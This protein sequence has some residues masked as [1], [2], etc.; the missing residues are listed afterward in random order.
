VHVAFALPPLRPG[1]LGGSE[2]NARG[3]LG[4]FARGNGPDEVTVLASKHVHEAFSE[5]ARGPVHLH[6]VASYPSGPSMATRAFGM[7]S[8][9]V[10]PGLVARHVPPGIEVLHHPVTVP[11]PR[12]RVPTVITLLDL[13]H[14]GLPAHLSS[15]ERAYRRVAYERAARRADV[16]ITISEHSRSS[17]IERA[18]LS[19][20]RV[21]VVPPGIDRERFTPTQGEADLRLRER[22]ALPGR[23]LVYPANLWPHKNHRRLLEALAECG[24]D[25]L[26]LVLSGRKHGRLEAL[27]AEARSMGLGDRVRHTGVLAPDELPVLLRGAV[28]MVFPSFYED[29]GAPLLEAMA[30]GCPVACSDRGSLRETAGEAALSF[31]PEYVLSIAEAL[32]RIASDEVL[33]RRLRAAGL[34]RAERFTWEAA[35]ASH[36][37]IYARAAELR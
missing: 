27:L 11:V 15:A 36:R 17:L 34:A 30:C 2:T 33:R 8:A 3:L 7:L 23:Y 6:R 5:Y 19:P 31:N 4:Q 32:D 16:V 13:Q 18:G 24:D 37:A 28:A 35:A 20:E 25:E 22:L 1:H 21:E 29:F 26:G 9:L 10:A 12:L 14:I